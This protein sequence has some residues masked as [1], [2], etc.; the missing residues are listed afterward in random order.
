MEFCWTSEKQC[1]VERYFWGDRTEACSPREPGLTE[2]PWRM[3]ENQERGVEDSSNPNKQAIPSS[4]TLLDGRKSCLCMI[5]R[6]HG[7]LQSAER[8]NDNAD[9]AVDVII[10]ISSFLSTAVPLVGFVLTGQHNQCALTGVKRDVRIGQD[11]EGASQV[12]LR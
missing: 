1:H 5:D 10:L 8:W 4:E 6:Y 3:K 12:Q 9:N 11:G 7:C 2:R